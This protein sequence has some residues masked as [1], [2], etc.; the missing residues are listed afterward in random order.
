MRR[1]VLIAPTPSALH[2]QDYGGE[3]YEDEDEEGR[4]EQDEDFEEDSP[5]RPKHSGGRPGSKEKAGRPGSKERA[6]RPGSKEKTP[7]AAV[8]PRQM[9]KDAADHVALRGGWAVFG[10]MVVEGGG[11]QRL[12]CTFVA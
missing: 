9:S 3:D 11:R 2:V 4:Y 12:D 7:A 10:C 6:G 8:Q 1:R 5:A